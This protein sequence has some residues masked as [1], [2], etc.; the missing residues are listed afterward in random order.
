MFGRLASRA[1]VRF[2]ARNGV[3]RRTQKA[4]DAP[5][6]EFKDAL[7]IGADHPA[8]QYVWATSAAGLLQG[9]ALAKL[10]DLAASKKVLE[11]ISEMQQ[12]IGDARLE[13]TRA[14]MDSI[15]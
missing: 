4:A 12:R 14:L 10:G 11:S 13:Q 9:Q 15:G 3:L 2:A 1:R 5:D 8:S 6:I 7:V